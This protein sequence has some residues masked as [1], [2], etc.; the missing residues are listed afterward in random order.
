MSSREKIKQG[1]VNLSRACGELTQ[2]IRESTGRKIE[3]AGVIQAFEFTF[4]TC[5]H[6]FQKIAAYQGTDAA[7]PR[8][9]IAAAF[10]MNLIQDEGVW[11]QMMKDRN[12]TSHTYNQETAKAIYDAIVASYAPEIARVI[13]AI[14]DYFSQQP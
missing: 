2:F 5:W 1:Q 10:Q 12:R 4:E 11:L 13:D 3:I 6:L 9:A 14:Q 8:L 7:M